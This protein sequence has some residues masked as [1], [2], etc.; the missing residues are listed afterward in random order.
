M[1]LDGGLAPRCLESQEG[2][3]TSLL[4]FFKQYDEFLELCLHFNPD[5]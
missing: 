2:S 4:Q 3:L 5:I 1:K